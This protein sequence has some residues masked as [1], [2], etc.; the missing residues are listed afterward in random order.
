MNSEDSLDWIKKQR[1]P[2]KNVTVQCFPLYSILLALNRTVIDFFSLDIEG[3]ELKV[4]K[5]IPWSKVHIKML[6]VE[7]IHQ[8]GSDRELKAYM[9]N[10]GYETILKMQRYDNKANDLIFRKRNFIT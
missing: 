4:L 1:L 5:T 2:L 3:D 6:A 9:E 8:P 7:F 10:L